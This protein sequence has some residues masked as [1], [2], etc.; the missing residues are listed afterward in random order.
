VGDS[1]KGWRRAAERQSERHRVLGGRTGWLLVSILGA[2]ACL[3]L[4]VPSDSRPETIRDYQ[5]AAP[6]KLLITVRPEPVITRTVTV[7]PDGKISFD[8]IGELEV[9]GKTIPNVRQEIS[10]R[11]KDFIVAPDVTVML[12]ESLSRKYFIF[13][14]VGR[15]GYFPLVG[16]V[17]AVEALAAAGGPSRFASLNASRLTRPIPE[18]Q[19]VYP[20][21]YRDITQNGDPTTN[22]ELQPGDVIYVPPNASARI[23]YALQIVFFPLQQI[24]GLGRD[25]VIQGGGL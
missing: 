18:G 21:K 23:G 19:G 8:L 13:G 15:V 3:P 14:E 7:R 5:I 2:A 20:V 16:R 9:S 4:R 12:E 22:Y 6:D 1:S 24:F 10:D 11:I 25:T 17:T